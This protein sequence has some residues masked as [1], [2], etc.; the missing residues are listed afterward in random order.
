MS[1]PERPPRWTFACREV[2]F[3]CEWR[4]NAGSVGEIQTRFLDHAKCAHGLR[5]L[6]TDLTGRVEAAARPA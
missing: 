4:L 2:G 6:P 5:E 3:S 1:G